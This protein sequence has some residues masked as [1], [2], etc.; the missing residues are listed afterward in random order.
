MGRLTLCYI[1]ASKTE[2]TVQLAEESQ[3]NQSRRDPTS[4]AFSKFYYGNALWHDGQAKKPWNNGMP[5]PE[6]A[7][8]QWLSARQRA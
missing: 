5:H 2:A 7:A 1:D 4:T 3:R 6:R 8:V